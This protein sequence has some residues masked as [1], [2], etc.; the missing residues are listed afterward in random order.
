MS[1][2]YWVL[3][4]TV[5]CASGQPASLMRGR[6]PNG[7]PSHQVKA[8]WS[9]LWNFTIAAREFGERLYSVMVTEDEM[10]KY[11]GGIPAFG[12]TRLEEPYVFFIREDVYSNKQLFCQVT[13]HEMLHQMR[14]FEN[15]IFEADHC[16]P[17][18][19]QMEEVQKDICGEAESVYSHKNDYCFSEVQNGEK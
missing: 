15:R 19:V 8:A 17:R 5:G 4:L 3:L 14:R 11:T 12:L 10:L 13:I 2:M 1:K 7:P 9:P 18:F 16:D 6:A